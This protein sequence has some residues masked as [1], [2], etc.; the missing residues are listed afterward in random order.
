MH[1]RQQWELRR[2]LV[3]LSGALWLGLAQFIG[4]PAGIVF[5]LV[6]LLFFSYGQLVQRRSQRHRTTLQRFE[7]RFR[8]VVLR[9]EHRRNA[10]LLFQGLIWYYFS[11]GLTLLI[12]PW[13]PLNIATA[14]CLFLAIGDGFSTLVGVHGRN[15][16]AGKKTYEGTLAFFGTSFLV[17]LVLLPPW[18]AGLGALSAALVELVPALHAPSKPWSKLWDDNLLIPFVSAAA[19]MLAANA[20]GLL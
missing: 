12:F 14:A 3:H 16:L 19:M 18:L 10:P 17:G 5:L 6:S 13:E 7:S 4:P 9:F 2:K 20:A 1:Y 15:R 11:S 8:E